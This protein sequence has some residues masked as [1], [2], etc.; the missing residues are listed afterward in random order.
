MSTRRR[1]IAVRTDAEL[2][3]PQLDSDMRELVDDYI[4]LPDG[5]SQAELLATTK[6]ADLILMCYTPIQRE[7]IQAASQLRGIVKY[8]V[9]IDAIDMDAAIEHRVPVCNVPH[10][11]EQTVAEGAFCLLLALAKK[12]I[13]IDREMHRS[14]WFW[15]ERRWL[16]SDIA[17]K[18]VGL[19]GLGKIGRSMARMAGAGFAANVIAFDPAV[20]RSTMS[21]AGAHKVD[22]LTDLLR[23]ADFVSLHCVLNHDTHHLLG[24]DEFSMMKDG[25]VLINVSRGDLIDETALLAALNTG[26]LVGA[27][28][29][30]FSQEPLALH[31]HPASALFEHPNVILSP[32]ITFYT[33]EAMQRLE[34]ET[35]ARCREVLSD[36]PL[37]V[38]STD[39]RLR[40]QSH[41]VVFTAID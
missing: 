5:V 17:G 27:G 37:Q 6:E 1:R 15:P 2:Q 39:P 35:L 34:A 3:C 40:R 31:N 7:V 26:K 8:G 14:G 19:I 36:Q 16:A 18:T 11:A 29:D 10:Y 28:L 22:N 13:T 20:D 32:H 21:R 23:Q 38:K 41:G 33:Q 25:A 12:L 24:R 30:V 9:G 4:L